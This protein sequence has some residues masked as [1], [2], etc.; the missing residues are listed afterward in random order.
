MPTKNIVLTTDAKLKNSLEFKK[1]EKHLEEFYKI[2]V[3]G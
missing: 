1:L 3:G 2:G